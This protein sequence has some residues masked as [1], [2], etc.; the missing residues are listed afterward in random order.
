[1]KHLLVLALAAAAIGACASESQKQANLEVSYRAL[2]PTSES[3]RTFWDDT[4]QTRSFDRSKPPTNP[5]FRRF[6]APTSSSIP[7]ATS[8]RP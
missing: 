8:E 3:L 4:G 1:M 5:S 6:S 7:E 2:N